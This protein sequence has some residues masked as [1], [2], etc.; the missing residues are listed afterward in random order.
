MSGEDA[1]AITRGWMRARRRGGALKGCLIVLAVVALLAVVAGVVVWRNWRGWA[2]TGFQQV[3]DQM[4]ASMPVSDAERAEVK[5]IMDGVVD[6]FRQGT[7]TTAE[8]GQVMEGLQNSP[9][10]AVLGA[11]LVTQQYVEPSSMADEQKA[12]ARLEIGRLARGLQDGSITEAK[13]ADVT[14]PIQGTGGPEFSLGTVR[15]ALKAPSTATAEE[16]ADLTARAKAAADEAGVPAE[17]YEVDASAELEKLLQSA[18]G[19]VPRKAAT[20]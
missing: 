13:L 14:T 8:M 12:E 7:L 5:P 3:S 16:L 1:M 6:E 18:I 17:A 20:P 19:R 10:L 2:A 15:I 11:G 9:L 4:V